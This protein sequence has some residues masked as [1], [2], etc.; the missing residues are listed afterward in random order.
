MAAAAEPKQLEVRYRR[1]LDYGTDI[2]KGGNG[3]PAAG[4]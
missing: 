3:R 1:F 2:A 4:G